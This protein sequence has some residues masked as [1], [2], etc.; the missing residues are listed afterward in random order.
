LDQGEGKSF[1]GAAVGSGVGGGRFAV[2]EHAEGDDAS[3]GGGAGS[4][5]TGVEDLGE[6]G[7]ESDGGGVFSIRSVILF[8]IN[9]DFL[10][11]ALDVVFGEDFGEGEGF[12]LN[13]RQE[14]LIG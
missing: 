9:A 11:A 12:V 7:P 13:E 2:E 1:A 8:S 4:M 14:E 5:R 3:D 6:E 10:L